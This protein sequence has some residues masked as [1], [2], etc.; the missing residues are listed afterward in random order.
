MTGGSAW[1]FIVFLCVF[2]AMPA[3]AG[4]SQAPRLLVLGDSL[5]AAYGIPR[6]QGWVALLQQR[7]AD[8][9][10]PHRVINAS[11]TGDTTVGGLTRLPAALE[12][13]RPALVIVEL[14]GNDGLRGF[15]LQQTRD[16]LTEMVELSR[17]AGALVLLAGVRL[18]GNYGSAYR[19]RFQQV[20]VDVSEQ[21]GAPLVP[22]LLAGVAETRDAMLADG[23]HPGAAAQPRI[24]DNVWPTLQGMLAPPQKP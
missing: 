3:F 14:G 4:E 18:P 9:G 8:Q 15:S 17:A 23:I 22:F 19:E 6:E 2:A 20:F 21:T 5:S 12:R 1:R 11:I 13:H 16:N 7:L 10:H 24:V